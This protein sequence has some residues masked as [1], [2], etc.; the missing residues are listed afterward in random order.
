MHATLHWPAG[1][2]EGVN[3]AQGAL[4]IH[5]HAQAAQ[6]R[7][8]SHGRGASATWALLVR[9]VS[10]APRSEQEEP[11]GCVQHCESQR[12]AEKRSTAPTVH[13]VLI[14]APK[15]RSAVPQAMG[16]LPAQPGPCW[17]AR[18]TGETMVFEVLDRSRRSE[19]AG[20]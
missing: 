11:W 18:S 8:T 9:L 1:S 3:R 20:A 4:G 12:A 6:C 7:C 16:A 15:Q 14:H 13:W 17:S 5:T 2:R 19:S 10:N